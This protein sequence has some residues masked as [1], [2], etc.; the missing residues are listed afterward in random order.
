MI[1]LSLKKFT[2]KTFKRER[3]GSRVGAQVWRALRK[4]LKTFEGAGEWSLYV[5]DGMWATSVGVYPKEDFKP[6][7]SDEIQVM[8]WLKTTLQV[9]PRIKFKRVFNEYSG[10]FHWELK[11]RDYLTRED[12]SFDLDLTVANEAHGCTMKKVEYTATKWEADCGAEGSEAG[13]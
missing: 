4:G 6:T 13:S 10:V 5:S 1:E 2:I 3:L 11:V 9:E 12:H 7:A 8:R